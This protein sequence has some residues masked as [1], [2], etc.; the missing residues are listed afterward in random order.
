MS[1]PARYHDPAVVAGLLAELERA[2]AALPRR[3][4][5]MEVCG[6]HTHTVARA[7]L[8]HRLPEA[9]RLISGPGC[10]VCV[11]PVGYLDRAEALARQHGAVL[12][13]F[14]DLMRVPSSSGSLEELS[15]EGYPVEVVYSPRDALAIARRHPGRPVVFL[16]VG[17]ETTVPTI[18]AALDEA[19]REGVDNLMILPGNKVMPPP[20]RALAAA[21][22][23]QVDGYLLPGHVSV[24]AGAES[25]RF[26]A[27]EHGLPSVVVGFTPADVLRGVVEIVRQLAAGRA[28]AVNLYD[29]VVTEEGNVV[30]QRLVARYF[31]PAD[32][33]WRGLGVIPG[34][35]LALRPEWAHRDASR[36]PV[37]LP[38]PREPAGCRCGE[39]LKGVIEPPECPLFAAGCT[40]ERPV[41]AC[42]VSS[43]GT[44]A[45]WYRHDRWA[46]EAGA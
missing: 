25:F 9:V 38:E 24:I 27:E 31:E 22:D 4:T 21:A 35:G 12:V 37:D 32:A 46:A 44:C 13:T 29:R 1:G 11:T 23:V 18:A 16:A 33:E 19:E 10:P 39:V 8:R 43:E 15:A 20:M 41:G 3:I 14:G 5:V 30:A 26:L 36:L 6:T 17:F 42:M 7:G 40:P 45:A 34:S 2:A 28:E